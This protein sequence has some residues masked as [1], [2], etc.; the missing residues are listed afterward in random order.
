MCVRWCMSACKGYSRWLWPTKEGV[1]VISCGVRVII[2]EKEG[3]GRLL[4]IFGGCAFFLR[5]CWLLLAG[6]CNG[7]LRTTR[8]LSL[9]V[10]R[11]PPSRYRPHS[12]LADWPI[13]FIRPIESSGKAKLI[14]AAFVTLISINPTYQRLAIKLISIINRPLASAVLMEHD[15]IIDQFQAMEM[16]RWTKRAHIR[17]QWLGH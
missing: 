8:W 4:C 6:W 1:F 11:T 15:S 17:I 7:S 9:V 16:I 14:L 10:T 13:F 2:W 12:G 3:G 5:G